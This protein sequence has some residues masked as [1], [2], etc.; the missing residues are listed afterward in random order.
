MIEKE[1]EEGFVKKIRADIVM[2]ARPTKEGEFETITEGE[3]EC[4]C[5]VLEMVAFIT[6]IILS[7]T[8]KDSGKTLDFLKLLSLS[9]AKEFIDVNQEDFD[10]PSYSER[11]E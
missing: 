10:M 4:N 2:G 3:L 1:L 6:D 5:T 11:E 7:F 8:E 9:L